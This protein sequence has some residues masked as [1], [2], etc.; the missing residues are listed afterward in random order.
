MRT[1]NGERQLQ[2]ATGTL[3]NYS[4]FSAIRNTTKIMIWQSSHVIRLVA[5]SVYNKIVVRLIIILKIDDVSIGFVNI[6]I[7]RHRAYLV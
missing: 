7:Y 2:T 1:G 4:W 3:A 6:K 5:V